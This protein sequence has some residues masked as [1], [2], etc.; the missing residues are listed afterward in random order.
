MPILTFERPILDDADALVEVQMRAFHHDTE[1]YG[2]EIGGPPGYDS[3]NMMFK[4]IRQGC[5]H[6]ILLDGKLIGGIIIFNRGDGHLHLDRLF[7][8]P[9]YHNH[10]YGTE[11]VRYIE[12]EC[13]ARVWTLDTPTFATRNQHFYEKLGYEQ[14]GTDHDGSVELISYQKVM[15]PVK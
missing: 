10:G 3:L 13:P 4:D 12:A 11:A 14:V 8:D 2:V 9:A 5:C 6:K 15:Q 7:I 1:Q